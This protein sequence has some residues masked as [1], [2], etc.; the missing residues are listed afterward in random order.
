MGKKKGNGSENVICCSYTLRSSDK[1]QHLDD[2]F[3]KYSVTCPTHDVLHYNVDCRG[4]D[5]EKYI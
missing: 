2:I 1:K 5:S 3:Q 4:N